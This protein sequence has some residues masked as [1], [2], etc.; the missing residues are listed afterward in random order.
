MRTPKETPGLIHGLWAGDRPGT[1]P[2]LLS[3]S[4]LEKMSFLGSP[5]ISSISPG[6][7]GA[8]RAGKKQ[9]AD[10]LLYFIL[11]RTTCGP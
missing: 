5:P 8:D 9:M 4:E 7:W 1:E 2:T 3:G 10:D 11:G 6:S